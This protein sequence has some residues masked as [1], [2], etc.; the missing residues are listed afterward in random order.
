MRE[1]TLVDAIK[2]A[3]IEELDRDERVYMVG[4]DIQGGIF[5]HTMELV[6]RFGPD[7]I[8][9]TPIAESGMFGTAFGSALAGYRPIV[10]FMF[11]NF[12]Y[13]TA[14]EV[15]VTAA[16]QYFMHG[17]QTPIPMVI[18]AGVGTTMQL[19]NDHAVPPKAPLLHQPGLKY[20][21]PST[22]YDAKG[23]MKSAIRDNNPVVMFWH[24]GMMMDRGPVPE[25][26]YV[27]PLGEAEV[28]R[29]GKDVTVLANGLMLKYAL[30]VADTLKDEIDIEI[31][32]P[33]SFRP[34][35]LDA[36]LTSLDKTGHLVVVDEDFYSCGWAADVAAQVIEHGF[37]MLDAPILRVAIDDVPI[38]GGVL[39][40]V[41]CPTP[42]KIEAAVRRVFA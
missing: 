35:D 32:D 14:S 21:F 40:P 19:G 4:Q 9:D 13:V 33:R 20:C 37:D 34:F 42:E 41:V 25:E 17:S 6:E 23:L 3:Y 7:R 22:P 16:Q 26:D 36:V 10:D 30:Q 15:M 28:K 5:P 38:P 1:L 12:L 2:E 18:T 31:V 24:M 27:I 39:E 29:E 8:V 11:G